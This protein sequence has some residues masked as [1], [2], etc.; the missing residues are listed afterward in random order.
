MA[1]KNPFP[2]ENNTGHI[3]DDNLRELENPPPQWWMIAFWAQLFCSV[4]RLIG[5]HF[6]LLAVLFPQHSGLKSNSLPNT[7]VAI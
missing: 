7:K 3:W 4:L 2:G 1:D 6:T 5:F